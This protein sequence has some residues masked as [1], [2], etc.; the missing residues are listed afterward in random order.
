MRHCL[1]AL[2]ALFTASPLTLAG[3]YD[4]CSAILVNGVFDRS[5]RARSYTSHQYLHRWLCTQSADSFASLYESG[6]DN[7]SDSRLALDVIAESIPIG[8]NASHGRRSTRREVERKL[9]EWQSSHCSESDMTANAT[10]YDHEFSQVA[11]GPIVEAWRDCVARASNGLACWA[12]PNGDLLAFHMTWPFTARELTTLD[13]SLTNVEAL[14]ALPTTLRAG[15]TSIAL[16]HD[17]ARA[18]LIVVNAGNDDFNVACEY[19]LPAPAAPRG[20]L[21]VAGDANFRAPPE[22]AGFGREAT[23]DGVRARLYFLPPPLTG[24]PRVTSA[25]LTVHGD[26]CTSAGAHVAQLSERLAEAGTSSST[27]L[28]DHPTRTLI[29]LDWRTGDLRERLIVVGPGADEDSGRCGLVKAAVVR[30]GGGFS[31]ERL[32]SLSE[33]LYLAGHTLTYN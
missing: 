16:R 23:Y 6:G 25:S 33:A 21:Q 19:Q 28:L 18:G 30:P 12:E 27:E 8:F 22:L 9:H 7:S 24:D 17:G 2:I 13:M 3:T 31:W 20:T 11:S 29:A 14:Q 15:Q 5:Q 26:A 1:I 32:G 4:H 10:A